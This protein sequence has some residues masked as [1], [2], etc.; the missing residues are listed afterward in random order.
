MRRKARKLKAMKG[1]VK[2]MVSMALNNCVSMSENNV[3]SIKCLANGQWRQ[4]SVAIT[5]IKWRGLINTA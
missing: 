5:A 3:F 2:L 4:P 1:G